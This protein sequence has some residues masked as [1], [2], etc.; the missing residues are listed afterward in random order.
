MDGPH[1]RR[2]KDRFTA[3][4]LYYLSP[5]VPT[6]TGVPSLTVSVCVRMGTVGSC[7]WVSSGPNLY[8]V[9]P[10]SDPD[11]RPPS[12]VSPTLNRTDGHRVLVQRS[13]SCGGPGRGRGRGRGREGDRG[14]GLPEWMCGEGRKLRRVRESGYPTLW[15]SDFDPPD[16]YPCPPR[17]PFFRGEVLRLYCLGHGPVCPYGGVL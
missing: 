4:P 11:H 2:W 1:S 14:W 12:S 15:T 5:T 8:F 9:V 7:A 13:P 10:L 3:S 6:R 17:V 16:P